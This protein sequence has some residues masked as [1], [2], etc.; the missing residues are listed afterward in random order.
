MLPHSCENRKL[1]GVPGEL[2]ETCDLMSV[3]AELI[4][5]D[6][7]PGKRRPL[8]VVRE[9]GLWCAVEPS[10]V[11][12]VVADDFFLAKREQ[13]AQSGCQRRSPEHDDLQGRTAASVEPSCEEDAIDRVQHQAQCKHCA[14]IFAELL[15]DLEQVRSLADSLPCVQL[16]QQK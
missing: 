7:D 11:E 3:V 6:D 4:L 8:Q 5:L 1:L 2:G 16:R 9:A 10:T 13:R 15:L 14:V 12:A